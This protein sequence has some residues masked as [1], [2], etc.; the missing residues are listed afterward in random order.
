MRVQPT[1]DQLA[2]FR[3]VSPI[4]HIDNVQAPLLFM[5]GAKDRRYET[6]WGIIQKAIDMKKLRY[7]H[8]GSY[9]FSAE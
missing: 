9:G 5:L 8:K 4:A 7:F 6:P 2:R 3:E 1:P